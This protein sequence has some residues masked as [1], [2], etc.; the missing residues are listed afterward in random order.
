MNAPEMTPEDIE[1]DRQWRTR[2]GQPLPMLGCADIVRQ[3]LKTA[4]PEEM[5]VAA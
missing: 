3:I 1:L 4:P 5:A 2:F